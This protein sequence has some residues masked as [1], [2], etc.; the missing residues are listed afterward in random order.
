MCLEK[1]PHPSIAALGTGCPR[2]APAKSAAEL[3][4]SLL[5]ACTAAATDKEGWRGAWLHWSSALELYSG[6]LQQA[7]LARY[8]QRGE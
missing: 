5:E 1:V 8:E 3:R 7:F 2:P 6:R 4:S